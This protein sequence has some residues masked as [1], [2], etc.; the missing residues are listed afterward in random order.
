MSHPAFAIMPF[1]SA[2]AAPPAILW[3]FFGLT[4]A[5]NAWNAVWLL[6]LLMAG[7]VIV[8]VLFVPGVALLRWRG[9][10]NFR[11]LSLVAFVA[12]CLPFAVLSWQ[13]LRTGPSFY[14]IPGYAY[15]VFVFGCLGVVGGLAY[16]V[17][18]RLLMRSNNRWRGP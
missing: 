18:V 16:W 2:A 12:G 5:P 6:Y 15:L 1:V 8:S 11:S 3:I 4:N 7:L 9:W 17:T 13:M 10:F 14:G